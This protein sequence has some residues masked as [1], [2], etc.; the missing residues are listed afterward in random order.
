MQDT[1]GV[2]LTLGWGRHLGGRKWQ[3]YS[4]TLDWKSHRQ[5]P[6]G[7]SSV[8]TR[9]GHDLATAQ[10]HRGKQITLNFYKT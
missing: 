6:A 8:D 10:A 2:D 7:Y 1:R 3:P 9:I 4:S 5:R